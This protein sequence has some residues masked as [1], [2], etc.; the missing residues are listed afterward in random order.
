M[1]GGGGDGGAQDRIDAN[2]RSED[3][4]IERINTMFGKPSNRTPA[5]SAIPGVPVLDQRAQAERD[6]ISGINQQASANAATRDTLY[7][8][9]GNDA[10]AVVTSQLGDQFKRATR[11]ANIALAR[12]GLTGGGADIAAQQEI[13]DAN[14]EGMLKADQAAQRASNQARTA[15]ESAR[16]GIM[17][18]IRNG[19][20]EADA[21]T[22]AT[23]KMDSS[24]T[25]ARDDAN[26]TELADMFG[27]LSVLNAQEAQTSAYQQR[28]GQLRSKYGNAGGYN[29]SVT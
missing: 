7:N 29:G 11:N 22:A 20:S 14:T 17:E 27:N 24:L 9:V 15:D 10:K 16:L 25:S 18:A 21:A 1:C 12:R 23:A 26:Q 19:M 4:A 8:T 3:A 6:Q 5:A 13:T 28:L 2:K